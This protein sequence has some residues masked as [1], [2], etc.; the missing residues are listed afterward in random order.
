[1]RRIAYA[2]WF[3]PLWLAVIVC[4]ALPLGW[5]G[6]QILTHP[7]G[8]AELRLDGFRWMLLGRTLLFNGSAGV[9]ATLLG[10]PAAIV[11]GRGD[12]RLAALAW[13]VLPM[14]L[15]VPSLT[16]AYGWAEF[17]QFPHVRRVLDWM[18]IQMT[19]AG[20]ADVFRCIWSLATWLWAIPAALVGLALLRVDSN[21]QQHALLDGALWRITAR[22]L[23]GPV[24]ASVAITTILA[25][26]EFAVY[27]PTGISVVA[28]EVR[29]VFDTGGSSSSLNPMTAPITP[30]KNAG[31]SGPDQAARAAAALV[32]S[33]PLLAV[34]AMLGAASAWAVRN[35]AASDE[36]ESGPVPKALQAGAAPIVL[37]SLSFAIAVAVPT[38]S[39]VRSLRSEFSFAR[40]W[41]EYQPQMIG[42]IVLAGTAAACAFAIAVCGSVRRTRLLLPL[43]LLSFLAGGQMLAIALIRLYNRPWLTDLRGPA[44][45]LGVTPRSLDPFV[46]IYN[47]IPIVTMAYLARFGWL[48]LCAAAVT[49]SRPWR[50]L[51]DVAAVDGAGPGRTAGSVIWPLTWPIL[52]ASAALVMALSLTEVP[53]TVLLYPM[54]PQAFT[55]ML[56]SWVHALNFDPMIEGSLLLMAFVLL[57]GAAA[58]ALVWMGLTLTRGS[59]WRAAPAIAALLM[60]AG[61]IGCGDTNQ[62]RTVWCETGTGP[63]EVVYPRAITYSPADDSFFIIDRVAHVQHLDHDGR[64]LCEWQMPQWKQGKPVGAAV[65]PDGKLWVPDTHYHRVVVYSPEGKLLKILGREGAGDGEFLLPT[66]IAFDGDRIFVSEYGGNDRVQVFDHDWH[67]LYQFGRFGDGDGEFSRPQSMVIDHGLVYITDACNHRLAVFTTAGKWVRNIGSAGSLLGQ[68]RFP[69]G[70]DEDREGHLI[71]CEFGNNRIQMID[72]ETGRGLKTWGSPGREPGQLA[73]PWGVAVDKRDRIVAVDAGNN[74]LQV[75]SF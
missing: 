37:A 44:R 41:H 70:L 52:L 32:T 14:S 55:P 13:F 34:I 6:V 72:K 56:M 54:R 51:R 43:M 49:W 2:L 26:Q 36:I 15:L 57:L 73:Y 46:W 19:L 3:A 16:Y 48:P 8:I 47:G 4:C 62:P 18:H 66:D 24:L 40:F 25:S 71:V 10:L 59:F 45:M 67:K 20:P 75:F 31:P 17:F 38:E 50:A 58:A 60:A 63:G 21:L 22:Q 11:I 42:S 64:C 35:L 53:A 1:M 12:R 68:F 65:A 9:L 61:L 30:A 39:M 5:M 27:E 69:Y 29:M 33:L 74:R 23:A 7:R 28:T